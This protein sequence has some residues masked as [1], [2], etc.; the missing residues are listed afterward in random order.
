MIPEAGWLNL[1][2]IDGLNPA[3]I[4][5]DTVV[6]LNYDK[7]ALKEYLSSWLLYF[8]SRAWLI[9]NFI[10]LPLIKFFVWLERHLELTKRRKKINRWFSWLKVLKQPLQKIKRKIKRKLKK[11]FNKNKPVALV[12]EFLTTNKAFVFSL[13]VTLVIGLLSWWTYDLIFK[14]LPAPTDLTKKRQILTTRILDRNGKLLYRIYLDENR[15][16]VPLEL[17]PQHAINATLAI[18]DRNFY[19]HHG[20]SLKGIFRALVNNL[21]ED[22]LQGGST[23][24]QQLVKNRLLTP[25]K[26]IRRKLRELLL[27]ILVEGTYTKEEILEMYLNEVPY[28]GSIYGIEEAAWKYFGKPAKDLSLGESTMLAGLPAAP[29]VYTPF[30][31]NPEL[32]QRRREEVLRRMVEDNYI[33]IEEAYRAQQEEL[34]LRKNITDIKAPHFVMYV[35]QLLADQYGED[36]LN[37]GGL[38]VRTSLDL[39]LQQK[40]EEVVANEVSK[41]K[42]LNV[43]NGA[44]LVTNPQTGEILAMVGNTDYFDFEHDGQVNVVVRPRQPGSSIKPLTYALALEQGWTPW[45]MIEDS[46]ITYHQAGAEP[47]SP[48]NY[49]DKFHGQVTLRQALANSYNVPAVK[50]LARIGVDNLID[51]AEQMGVTTWKDRSRFGL[52]LTLGGGEVL[53]TDMAQLYG[54]FANGGYNVKLKP[55]IEVKNAKGEVLYRNPCILQ[56]TE[57]KQ[58]RALDPLAAYQITSILSDDVARIPA[59]GRYSVLNIPGQEVAVKTGTSNN[60]RD[61]WAIGYTTNRLAAVWVGNNDNQPMSEIA[62]GITGASPI[63]N[64]VMSLMLDQ[65]NPHAFVLPDDLVR[66]SICAQTGTLPCKG[67]PRVVEEVFHRGQEP[68]QSCNWQYFVK[69]DDQQPLDQSGNQQLQRTQIL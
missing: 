38:E 21:K 10:S 47:Y 25:E 64:K 45:T 5:F 67:C 44:A 1:K 53:M 41:L 20:F 58:N 30:G 8:K 51:K 57:C 18:E 12:G 54:H 60:L 39:N 40:T 24:T 43:N 49:D 28:G 9:V 56:P 23:I 11:K 48:K 62:S 34:V 65:A 69:K 42:G 52:A 26:T 29:S 61:N 22:T 36:V 2:R 66:V 15:T 32:S 14:D 4:Q 31:P 7:T 68:T 55:F 46:P 63:W 13:F 6:K 50:T 16:I 27:A 17:I 35:K 59:F 33:T 37:Q 19:R 3:V